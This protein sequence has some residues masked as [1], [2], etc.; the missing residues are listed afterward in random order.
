MKRTWIIDDDST[1]IFIFAHL[2]RK[3]G[4]KPAQLSTFSNG[5]QALERFKTLSER[6]DEL[7]DLILLDVNMPHMSSWY[8]IE[9]FRNYKKSIS[10]DIKI[11]MFSSEMHATDRQ[12]AKL[13]KE[14]THYFLKPS[15]LAQVQAMD[16]LY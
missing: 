11:A 6:P 14:V 12:K 8:F 2:F 4:H 13:Y 5:R 1:Y 10:K 3:A 15:T 16:F 7:P 9:T